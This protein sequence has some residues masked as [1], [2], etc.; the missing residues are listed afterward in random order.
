MI[1]IDPNNSKRPNNSQ[2]LVLTEDV[3]VL[4]HDMI[5]NK[6][7]V[8]ITLPSSLRRIDDKAF[9]SCGKLSKPIN[10]VNVI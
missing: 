3:T 9:Q 1:P 6:D 2:H 7:I 5:P 10:Y 4:T 8:E